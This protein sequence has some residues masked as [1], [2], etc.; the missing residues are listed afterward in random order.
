[1]GRAPRKIEGKSGENAKRLNIPCLHIKQSENHIYY[2]KM[3]AS[4]AWDIFSISR[5]EPGGNEGYQRF[6]SEARVA[7]VAKYIR[8]GNPIPGSILVS[9]DK[10]TYDAGTSKLTIPRGKD[11]GW[12]ID[13]QHRLAGASEAAQE[14]DDIE[15]MVAAFVGLDERHQIQQFVTI[16]DEAKGVPRSLLLNLLRQIPDKSIQEQANERAIDIARQLNNSEPSVFFQRIASIVSPRSGEISDTNFS[17]KV[18]P[19]VHPEKGL[20]RAFSL[21]D[22]VKIID[23]YYTALRDI[24]PLEFRKANSVFFR[25]IGFGAAFN[26]F[27]EV[28]TRVLSQH[29]GF[30]VVDIKKLLRLISDY[31][32]DKWD[33]FGTGNQAEQTAGRDFVKSLRKAVKATSK[34]MS[35]AKIPL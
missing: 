33:Q 30:K 1:M 34:K 27:D 8:A 20:L 10:A 7:S 9:L 23:N 25:T 17:R 16:N 22:Q 26:A 6:L 2:F 15:L 4:Q 19:L 18:A 21:L 28:F 29:A 31:E 3:K 12:I 13:G 35:K 32:V 14:N 24:F 5:L 11:V